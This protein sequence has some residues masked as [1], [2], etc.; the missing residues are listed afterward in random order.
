MKKTRID[1]ENIVIRNGK[2]G[3][4]LTTFCCY[5][6][7]TNASEAVQK[8][9]KAQKD[10]HKCSSCYGLLNSQK[11]QSIIVKKEWLLRQ[12]RRS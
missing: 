1:Y 2:M 12:L 5:G 10:Y 8:T 7:G 11:N 9:A 4:V 6:Y 3:T